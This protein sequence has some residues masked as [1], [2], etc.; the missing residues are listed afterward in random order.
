MLVRTNQYNMDKKIDFINGDLSN[1]KILEETIDQCDVV[2]YAVGII[3][4]NVKKGITFEK[5]HFEYFRNFCGNV[6]AERRKHALLK[7]RN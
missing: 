7:F 2:V 3:R 1:K 5:L 4:E 6:N